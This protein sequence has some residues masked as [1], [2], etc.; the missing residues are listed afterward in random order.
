MTDV[1]LVLCGYLVIYVELLLASV[2]F[3]S[4]WW[5]VHTPLE[6]NITIGLLFVFPPTYLYIAWIG[7]IEI[8][9]SVNPTKE[10]TKW[11]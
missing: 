11:H 5:T 3:K 1:L 2:L 6:R 8:F 9:L 4:H 10:K 7:L